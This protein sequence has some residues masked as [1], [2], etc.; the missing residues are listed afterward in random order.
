MSEDAVV[1]APA[2][3][4]QELFLKSDADIIVYGGGMRLHLKLS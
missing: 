4:K 3:L 2:S 1:F